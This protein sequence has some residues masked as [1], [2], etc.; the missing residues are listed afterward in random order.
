[1]KNARKLII[2]TV[3]MALLASCSTSYKS[4]AAYDHHVIIEENK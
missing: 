3:A 2:A 1:M 4:C